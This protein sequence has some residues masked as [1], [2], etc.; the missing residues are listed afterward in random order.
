MEALQR[1]LV[2]AGP[3]RDDMKG[4][5][6]VGSRVDDHSQLA[7]VKR[8][9]RH[10]SDALDT[11]FWKGP[12]RR[13][14]GRNRRDRRSRSDWV[15]QVEPGADAGTRPGS[16]KRT[17]SLPSRLRSKWF[18][19]HRSWIPAPQSRLEYLY[20]EFLKRQAVSG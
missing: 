15:G 6:N 12:R 11:R 18:V 8:V 3:V 20:Y 5:V 16:R 2:E 14:A 17:P 1:N 13:C 4:R 10:A 7:D 19:T 9:P